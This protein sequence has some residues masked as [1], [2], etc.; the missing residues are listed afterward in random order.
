MEDSMTEALLKAHKRAIKTGNLQFVY[1]THRGYRISL[2]NPRIFQDVFC[3]DGHGDY[4]VITD[5]NKWGESKPL[6]KG[7][8]I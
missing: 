3:I 2:K 4:S 5:T 7:D 1:A 8:T 6:F